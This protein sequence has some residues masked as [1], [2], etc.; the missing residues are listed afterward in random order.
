MATAPRGPVAAW[1]LTLLAALAVALVLRESFLGMLFQWRT[2][3]TFSYGFLILPISLFLIWRERRQLAGL[4]P[5]PGWP[6]LLL[7]VPVGA[8]WVVGVVLDVN[9]VH[10]VA[11]VLLVV[12]A[13]WAVLGTPTARVIWFPLG[14]LLLMVPF[15]EFLVPT[16]MQWTADF[17]V[18]AVTLTGVPVFQDGYVFSLPS[19]DFEVIKACSGI[20]FLMATVAAGTVVAWVAYNS[21]RKRVVFLFACLVV[22][23][24]GNLLR[25]YL[26]VMLV[27]FS[28]GRLAGPHVLYGTIFSSTILL[29]LFV[30][31]ARYADQPVIGPRPGNPPLSAITG[32]DRALPGAMA[33]VL[34]AV[35]VA[36]GPV[37]LGG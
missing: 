28:D 15:G 22:S 13:V 37:A 31:A 21:W 30:F 24:L 35:A 26:V 12:L 19:G 9:V 18:L 29:S 2:S 33:S 6:A 23:V 14:Y 16:L 5:Q 7:M 11:A 32:A 27:H 20:R 8:C 34:L 17:A 1:L 4:R 25:A 10:H 36:S 3:S